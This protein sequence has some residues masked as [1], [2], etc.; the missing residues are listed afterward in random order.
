MFIDK[1]VSWKNIIMQMTI[2]YKLKNNCHKLQE[3]KIMQSNWDKMS[4]RHEILNSMK[5]EKAIFTNSQT[6]GNR[7]NNNTQ[8][9]I[10][11]F[12]IHTRH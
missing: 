1:I 10:F 11:Q 8:L 4:N 3:G 12:Y 6:N 5:Y 2:H 7:S 9:Y